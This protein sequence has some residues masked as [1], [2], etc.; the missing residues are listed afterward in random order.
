MGRRIRYLIELELSVDFLS[1]FRHGWNAVQPTETRDYIPQEVAV[2]EV[3][4]GVVVLLEDT[5]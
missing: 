5:F 1:D 2:V 4:S 3:V